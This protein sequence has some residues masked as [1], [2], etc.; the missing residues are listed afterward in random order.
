MLDSLLF[1]FT[2]PE[3]LASAAAIAVLGILVKRAVGHSL[4]KSLFPC[5]ES[6]SEELN[7]MYC[8]SERCIEMLH[9]LVYFQLNVFSSEFLKY[10]D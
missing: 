5:N 9:V 7:S 3:S 2:N 6:V 4:L 10:Q 8:V 1:T